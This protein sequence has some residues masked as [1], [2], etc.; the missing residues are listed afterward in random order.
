MQADRAVTTTPQRLEYHEIARLVPYG[1]RWLQIDRVLRWDDTSIIVQKAVSGGDPNMASHLAQGPSIMPG[2]L[3]VE[4]VNQALMLLMTLLNMSG[5]RRDDI[6]GAG[7]MARCKGNFVSP[8]RIGDILTATVT[9]D[10]VVGP[11]TAFTGVIRCGER[12]VAR[13]SALG[14]QLLAAPAAEVAP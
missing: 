2:A 6:A 8:A 7:V 11:A 14:T 3:Q 9:I 5:K 4:L 12:L 1:A 13:I 10:H